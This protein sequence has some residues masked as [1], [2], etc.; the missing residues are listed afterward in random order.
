M[1]HVSTRRSRSEHQTEQGN[2][3]YLRDVVDT[4]CLSS[5]WM[6]FHYFFLQLSTSSY[7]SI[8][9][10]I[11]ITFFV[12]IYYGYSAQ[13][14]KSR[15]FLVINVDRVHPSPIIHPHPHRHH[16]TSHSPA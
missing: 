10:I 6:N 1:R 7:S 14:T 4:R 8:L 11:F 9:V 16:R 13:K 12:I 2:F 5:V 15:R 3:Q